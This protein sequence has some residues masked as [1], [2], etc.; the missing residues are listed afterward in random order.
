M[1]FNY[2]V[3]LYKMLTDLCIS[4]IKISVDQMHIEMVCHVSLY[5]IAYWLHYTYL[6]VLIYIM[7]LFILF[8]GATQERN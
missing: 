3:T 7:Y 2:D 5:C 1:R 8:A 4:D 6:L